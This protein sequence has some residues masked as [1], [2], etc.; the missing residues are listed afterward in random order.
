MRIIPRSLRRKSALWLADHGSLSVIF[1]S[2]LAAVIIIGGAAIDC[3][4]YLD[5]KT[6]LQAA[7]DGAAL[8]VMSSNLGDTGQLEDL[9]KASLAANFDSDQH[10]TDADAELDTDEDTVTLRVQGT[11][12]TS[13][14]GLIGINDLPLDISAVATT[15]SDTTKS[16]ELAFVL[17][18]NTT[19]KSPEFELIKSAL[20]SFTQTLFAS[21]SSKVDIRMA[22]VPF[23]DGVN[24]GSR[25][26]AA[27]GP[28]ASGT[29]TTPGC[30]YFTFTTIYNDRQITFM[31]S[32]CVTER[33]GDHAYTDDPV[34]T[35]YVGYFYRHISAY[36]SGNVMQPLTDD[37]STLTSAITALTRNYNSAGHV[38]LAWG[39]YSLSPNIGMWNDSEMPAAYD[40]ENTSKVVVLLTDQDFYSAFCN[41]VSSADSTN[42]E[43]KQK[44]I[45]CNAPNGSARTQARTICT[46]M[47]AKGITIYTIGYK[48]STDANALE[49]LATCASGDS[50]QYYPQD[51]TAL[52]TTL[53]TLAGLLADSLSTAGVARLAD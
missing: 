32:T 1:A 26:E 51:S 29:C 12:R 46:A 6:A 24:L 52:S 27:R 42:A 25:A 22:L 20:A 18:A 36:C 5:A 44:T 13:F 10:D 11:Y 47:K 30:S 17:D 43:P 35:S 50:Y 19:I 4:R 7:A 49:T 53:G 16:L 23:S 2:G 31:D 48:V 8:Q 40:D 9:A 34:T 37:E 28:I 21:A 39:W 33:L 3:A 15:S 41:G 45:N 14:G 38:G